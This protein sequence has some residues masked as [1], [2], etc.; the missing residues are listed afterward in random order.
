MANITDTPPIGVQAELDALKILL[1]Q[2]IPKKNPDNLLIATWNIRSFGGLK[3]EWEPQGS[4]SPKRD[5]HALRIISD[6]VSRF[7]VVAIQEGK[8]ELTAVRQLIEALGGKKD[9]GVI[10]TDVTE[11]SKGNSERL[12]F[13]Y[14]RNRLTADGLAGELVVS[15]ELEEALRADNEPGEEVFRRQFARTPYAVSFAS[16]KATFVLVTLHVIWGDSTDERAEELEK[17]AVMLEKWAKRKPKNVWDSDFIALGDFNIQSDLIKV[18]T[19]TGLKPAEDHEGLRR[20]I[21]KS[22]KGKF[23]D[24]VAWF[25]DSSNRSKLDFDYVTGG[26]IDFVDTV[27]PGMST[28]SLSWRVSDH[29]PL[30]VEFNTSGGN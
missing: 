3:R 5:L 8:R 6:I 28:S 19:K 12:A 11:G 14:D 25:H 29:Y 4:Y 2:K 26:N 10:L 1:D 17:I 16:D 21:F 27:Y 22:S 13:V 30:W 9:W 7:D 18:F 23:Y 20:T 24:Q 15:R